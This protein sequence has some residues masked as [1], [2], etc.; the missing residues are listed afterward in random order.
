M[1]LVSC[2]LRLGLEVVVVVDDHGRICF[3]FGV[4]EQ[5][6]DHDLYELSFELLNVS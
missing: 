6:A 5:D 1:Y 3:M 2:E 4:A